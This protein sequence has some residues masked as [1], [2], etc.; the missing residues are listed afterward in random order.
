MPRP[1]RR[2]PRRFLHPCLH[3]L[4]LVGII[5]AATVLAE[6]VERVDDLGADGVHLGE[7]DVE[8]QTVQCVRDREQQTEAV[9]C[10]HLDDRVPLGPNVVDKHGRRHLD[11]R[12]GAIGR[13]RFGEAFG[14]RERTGEC[15]RHRLE[16]PCPAAFIDAVAKT[17]AH[18]HD[19]D[20]HAVITSKGRAAQDIGVVHSKGAR[21]QGED[22]RPIGRDE[23]ESIHATKRV[24][25]RRGATGGLADQPDVVTDH[26]G[27]HAEEVAVRELIDV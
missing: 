16:D 23:R 6:H 25:S 4:D 1:E 8:R 13:A 20:R 10:R 5:N 24:T 15:L 27:L 3:T 17:V 26:L 14:D 9:R 22:P 12:R 11:A 18:V 2:A 21:N 7:V 19:L